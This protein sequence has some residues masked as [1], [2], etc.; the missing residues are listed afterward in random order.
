[1]S[2]QFTGYFISPN[3][4]LLTM[5]NFDDKTHRRMST[6]KFKPGPK[7]S[8]QERYDA[9]AEQ[10]KVQSINIPPYIG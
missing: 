4:T 1:M 7:Q 2:E 6:V 10:L 8:R 3:Y 5:F 9:I